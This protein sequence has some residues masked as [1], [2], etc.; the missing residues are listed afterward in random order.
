M[1]LIAK[2]EAGNQVRQDI[3]VIWKEPEPALPAEDAIPWVMLIGF[4]ACTL[5]AIALVSAEVTKYALI[6]TLLP[7]FTRLRKEEVLDH[8][9][10]YAI[11]GLILETPGIHYNAIIKELRL[12]NGV[13]VYH[14]RVLEQR[15]FIKAMRDGTMKRFYP[16]AV[17][18]PQDRA[19]TPEEIRDHIVAVVG[20]AP[21]IS[22]KDVAKR[23]DMDRETVGYHLRELSREGSLKAEKNGRFTIYRKGKGKADGRHDG[24]GRPEDDG[25]DVGKGDGQGQ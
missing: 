23:L 9:L 22:Q 21:G 15:G 25:K 20:S 6:A 3:G 24:D 16:T 5:G 2:D 1:S 18:L 11:N 17:R 12:T 8:R 7:M 14:L 19:P 10:R 4:T 13:A